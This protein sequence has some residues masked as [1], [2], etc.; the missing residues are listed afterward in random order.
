MAAAAAYLS[1]TIALGAP[2]P[3]Q[4]EVM[5]AQLARLEATLR[6]EASRLIHGPFR[7]RVLRDGL[8]AVVT[9]MR[10]R[11]GQPAL[12][13]QNRPLA[14]AELEWMCQEISR[15]AQG[16]PV[17]TA[18]VDPAT[19]ERLSEDEL[20]AEGGSGAAIVLLRRLTE[21]LDRWT[22]LC[23]PK[24][25]ALERE[26][27]SLDTELHRWREVSLQEVRGLLEVQ[28]AAGQQFLDELL[29]KRSAQRASRPL[30]WVPPPR[31]PLE[32][33]RPPHDEKTQRASGLVAGL[34]LLGVI[35]ATLLWH[36]L[37]AHRR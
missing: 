1:E 13:G 25:V 24:L 3:D 26:L 5:R 7:D 27:D 20:R 31:N 30:T 4:L 33:E 21:P 15:R 8:E 36:R 22:G 23:Y 19:L 14:H 35:A 6:G 37:R 16:A 2:G 32:H 34:A 12:G 29:A 10:E 9:D 17:L 28:N 11:L 18:N